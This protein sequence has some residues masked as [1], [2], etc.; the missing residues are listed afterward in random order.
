MVQIG[1]GLMHEAN[2]AKAVVQPM[3]RPPREDDVE[4]LI[5]AVHDFGHASPYAS[6]GPGAIPYGCFSTFRA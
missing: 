6:G 3:G 2:I 1:Q 5:L 4:V